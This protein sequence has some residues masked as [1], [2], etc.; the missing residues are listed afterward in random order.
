MASSNGEKMTDYS[1]GGAQSINPKDIPSVMDFAQ[2]QEAPITDAVTNLLTA[3]KE[4]QTPMEIYTSLQEKNGIPEQQKVAQS[5]RDRIYGLED[6]LKR[7]GSNVAATTKNSFVTEAQREGMV[8]AQSKP[9]QNTLNEAS[10]SY[11][12]VSD[13]LATSKADVSNLT[14]LVMQGNQQALEP[15]KTA[16]SVMTD[17]AARL[18]SAFSTDAQNKLNV[19]LDQVH[20]NQ[21]LSDMDRQ[22]AFTLLQQESS[23]KQSIKSSAASSGIVLKGNE[24]SDDI[25]NKIG[26]AAAAKLRAAN[27]AP[28][29]IS[30]PGFNTGGSGWTVVPKPSN[31]GSSSS[32]LNNILN[33]Y[34]KQN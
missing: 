13:D 33:K 25:L 9:I 12:R 28:A 5:L 2:K 21:Q 7:V 27:T 10:T 30:I 17:R 29:S 3:Q 18:T 24:S 8:N 14:N 6:S 32:S 19:M 34:I 20:R 31:S 22:E 15:L 26:S 16:V 23:Y 4:Q 11:G 1:K